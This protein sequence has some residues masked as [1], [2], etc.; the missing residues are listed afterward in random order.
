M[1]CT[2]EDKKKAEFSAIGEP[3]FCYSPVLK[4]ILDTGHLLSL[5]QNFFFVGVDFGQ[6]ICRHFVPAQK[7]RPNISKGGT[8]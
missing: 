1:R 3:G 2:L 5:A 8:L 6:V 7:L 4:S